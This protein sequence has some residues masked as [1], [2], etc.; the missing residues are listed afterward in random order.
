MKS[1]VVMAIALAFLLISAAYAVQLRIPVV[2]MG[3]ATE[4]DKSSADSEAYNA[5]QVSANNLCAGTIENN[6]YERTY[7]SCL[8]QTDDDG[9]TTWTCAINV[10]AICVIGR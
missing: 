5:A 4:A 6:N 8:P 10:K 1:K 7:E 2:G 3:R 9:N